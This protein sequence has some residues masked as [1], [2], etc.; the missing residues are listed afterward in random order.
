MKKSQYEENIDLYF[1]SIQNIPLLNKEEEETLI[2]KIKE[3]DKKALDKLILANLR[4][5][6]SIA[7]KYKN[8]GIPFSDLISAGNVGLVEASKRFDPSK[9]V[10]FTTYASW[11]IKQSIA[12]TIWHESEIIKK[13]N[14]IHINA[15]KINNTYHYL[16]E[17]LGREPSIDEI[18]EFLKEQGTEIKREII[19]RHLL[20]NNIFL[21][22]NA[23]IDA[24]DDTL[25]LEGVISISDTKDIEKDI[26]EEELK[27]II[28][29]LL[30]ELNQREKDV[31]ILRFGLNDD[32]P[33][34][35][36]EIGEILGISRERVRQIEKKALKN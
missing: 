27:K 20:S 14:R 36:S 29:S 24:D 21:S 34:T 33:K 9:G 11:W 26:H 3:G 5:V 30:N 15:F 4:F 25:T 22:L 17:T 12:D 10:K 19:E 31:L 13:P 6:I 2:Q 1:K 7:K 32:E 16:K 18:A 28:K 23:S 8:Y 35:L